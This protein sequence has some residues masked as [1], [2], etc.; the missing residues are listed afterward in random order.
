[1][2]PRCWVPVPGLV[3]DT[4]SPET[5]STYPVWPPMRAIRTIGA[6]FHARFYNYTQQD[7]GVVSSNTAEGP[8]CRF[9]SLLPENRAELI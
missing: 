7:T 4:S 6:L 1:M 9:K 2:G 3:Q 5:A 8:F